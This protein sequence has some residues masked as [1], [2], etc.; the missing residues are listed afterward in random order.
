MAPDAKLVVV[1]L[2]QPGTGLCIPPAKELYTPGYNA[3]ARVSTNSWGNPFN[4]AGYY[5]NQDD[6]LY[7]YKRPVSTYTTLMHLTT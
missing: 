1:D 2:G 5:N 4:G 7:L 6:D 3:G